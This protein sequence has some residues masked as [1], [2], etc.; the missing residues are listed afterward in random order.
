MKG[1]RGN[2]SGLGSVGLKVYIVPAGLAYRRGERGNDD[3]R[4]VP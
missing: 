1:E 4:S 3:F 2:E